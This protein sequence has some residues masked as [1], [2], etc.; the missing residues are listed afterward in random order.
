MFLLNETYNEFVVLKSLM[1][2][3][4]IQMVIDDIRVNGVTTN[5]FVELILGTNRGDVLCRYYHTP[6]E[7]KAVIFVGSNIGGFDSP[8][9]DLYP[10]LC[11]SL[12][13]Q[14]ISS[15]R[16]QYRYPDDLVECALD[17]LAGITFL[18]RFNIKDIGLI[19]HSFGGAVVLQAAVA[20]SDIVRTIATLAT[21]I[22]G[23]EVVTLLE[24]ASILFIHG[25]DDKVFPLFNS[26]YIHDIAASRKQLLLLE[27]AGHN[28]DTAGYDLH[29]FIRAWM[30][31]NLR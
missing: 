24:D 2:F 12:Q 15:L 25:T 30:I 10:H 19:G 1:E 28:F 18:E 9:N 21:Q 7:K 8:G 16:I 4:A 26:E 31:E 22:E 14:N 27:G 5:G 13:L 29:G 20:A 6:G 3:G 11:E 23:A 17:V